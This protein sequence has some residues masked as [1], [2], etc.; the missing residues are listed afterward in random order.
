MKSVANPN[1]R[2]PVA[3]G[4]TLA[5]MQAILGFGE[6]PANFAPQGFDWWNAAFIVLWL[7]FGPRQPTAKAEM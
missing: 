5:P 7:G 2:T 3:T 6:T 1:A 4:V